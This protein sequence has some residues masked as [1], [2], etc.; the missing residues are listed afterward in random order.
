MILLGI[1][2]V[3]IGA[4]LAQRFKIMVLVPATATM[5]I[6]A[7]AAGLAQA[8]TGWWVVLAAAIVGTSMQV[9]Y[10]VGLGIRHVLEA[11]WADRPQPFR[12]S[13]SAR[14]PIRLR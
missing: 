14:H 5:L 8:H 12:P 7:V 1:I 3:L 13:A 11:P 9:G 2:S 6:A 4:V 10:I